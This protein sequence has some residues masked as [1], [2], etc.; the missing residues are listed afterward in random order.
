M[1][2]LSFHLEQAIKILPGMAGEKAQWSMSPVIIIK[3]N[4]IF[5]DPGFEK[6]LLMIIVADD[7][8]HLYG[9]C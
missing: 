6:K 3:R 2:V 5:P 9:R 4:L 8:D 7:N 1:I